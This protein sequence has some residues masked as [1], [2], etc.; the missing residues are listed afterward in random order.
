M[1]LYAIIVGVGASAGLGWVALRAPRQQAVSW[2]TAGLWVLLGTLV[3]ARAAFVAANWSYFQGHGLEAPQIWLGGLF[4]PGAL[5]GALLTLL[6]LRLFHRVPA[7]YL[8]EG[9]LPLA[10]PVVIASWLGCWQAGCAYGLPAPG[11]WWALPAPDEWGEWALRWPLQTGG[12]LLTLAWF[13]L[14]ARIDLRLRRP[15][16]AASLVLL[17]LGLLLLGLSLL[18][19]DHLPVF[20]GRELDTWAAYGAIILSVVGGFFSILRH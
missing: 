19:A 16:L 18:R 14:V 7:A 9:L 1:D 12:A 3:G 10:L 6:V 13:A 11:A 17:G 2:V 5:A 8:S 15:A 20:R 4:W